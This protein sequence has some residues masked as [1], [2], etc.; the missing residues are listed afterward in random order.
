[1]ANN[2]I[3]LHNP[4]TLDYVSVTTA[5]S[6]EKGTSDLGSDAGLFHLQLASHE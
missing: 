2:Y 1:M 4:T 5:W 6:W 3:G